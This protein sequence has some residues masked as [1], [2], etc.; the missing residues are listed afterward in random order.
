MVPSRYVVLDRLPLTPNGK[1]DRRALLAPAIEVPGARCLSHTP[2]T[3]IVR[4][5]NATEHL[6]ARMMRDCLECDDFGIFESFFD[7][8][9][10]SLAALRLI[11]RLREETGLDLPLRML[12]E[13]RTVAA[14]SEALDAMRWARETVGT[15]RNE[16][17]L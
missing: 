11:T 17:I 12:F 5:R 15:E 2:E 10:H 3:K 8:G 16:V 14:I 7:L 4:P 6:V 1:L 9:G 13:R